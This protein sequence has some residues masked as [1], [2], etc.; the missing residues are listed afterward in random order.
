[1]MDPTEEDTIYAYLKELE[2]PGLNEATASERKATPVFSGVLRYF[3]DALA[4]VAQISKAGNDQHN[5]GQPLHW[6]KGKSTDHA[7]C[8]ARHLLGA[9]TL[10][11]DGKRHTAK[12]AWRALAL[13]QM[14]LESTR[15]GIS[16]DDHIDRL[17][18]HQARLDELVNADSDCA[19]GFCA[20]ECCSGEEQGSSEEQGPK[21]YIA[22]PMTGYEDHNYPAFYEA[23]EMVRAEG[24]EPI[25]PARMDEEAGR[26]GDER[27]LTPEEYSEALGE[28]LEAIRGCAA[29]F[30]LPGWEDSPGAKAEL[31][32]AEALGLEIFEIL[33]D[34]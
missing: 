13:L 26:N 24:F 7:D 18:T 30:L 22:G 17:K 5:P 21:A 2:T 29:I 28:D 6:A 1:M 27:E 16:L 23:E 31:A 4:E 32:L 11:A 9:G 14:E 8:I 25:N 12:M 10:D 34:E 33:D 20:T 19:T 3:P 15:A